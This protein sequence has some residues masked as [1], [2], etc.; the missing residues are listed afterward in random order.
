V[1]KTDR[2]TDLDPYKLVHAIVTYTYMN[3]QFILE[4][5]GCNKKPLIKVSLIFFPHSLEKIV[6]FIKNKIRWNLFVI[7]GG[8][9]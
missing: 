6:I 7:F 9:I 4:W 5:R 8:N 1:G 2:P 3:F